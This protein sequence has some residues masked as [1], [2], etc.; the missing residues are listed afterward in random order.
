M[1]NMSKFFSLPSPSKTCAVPFDFVLERD[2]KN[3]FYYQRDVKNYMDQVLDFLLFDRHE[4]IHGIFPSVILVGT[5]MLR[6]NATFSL[7][8]K[9]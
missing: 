4:Y 1:K 7:F 6:F 5:L 9:I 3:I 8:F 2:P